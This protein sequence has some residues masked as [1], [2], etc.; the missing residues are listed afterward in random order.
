[1]EHV[2]G[3][4]V[5]C[6]GRRPSIANVAEMAALRPKNIGGLRGRV[7]GPEKWG[8]VM[9]AKIETLLAIGKQLRGQNEGIAGEALPRRWIDLIHH[10][11]GQQSQRP[12]PE[13]EPRDRPQTRV[14]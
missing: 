2:L 7:Q 3:G 11:N 10:L 6:V 1:M 13:A 14:N 9:L 8:C 5:S 12:Q 4:H